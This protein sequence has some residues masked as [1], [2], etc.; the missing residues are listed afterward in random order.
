VGHYFQIQLIVQHAVEAY[1]CFTLKEKPMTRTLL[2]TG[3]SGLVSSALIE[4][5]QNSPGLKLRALLRDGSKA[6]K[7]QARGIE[8]V[9]GD[10]D[11]PDSLGAAL[12]G[13]NDLWLLTAVGPRA[14][15]NSMNALW[16]AKRAGVERV[17]RMS[18]IGAAH[19]APSR[20]GRLHALSDAELMASSL[21]WT[22]LRP[23]FFT[24][25]LLASAAT[26]QSQAAFYWDLGEGKLGMIDAR[27]IGE[28]A[29][30]VLSSPPDVHHGKVYTL[31]GPEAIS[32]EQAAA[33][34]SQGLGRTI[35]YVPVPHEVARKNMLELGMPAWLVGMLIEYG[36]AY[37]ENWG[38]FTTPHVPELLGRP[39]RSVLDFARDHVAAFRS[40]TA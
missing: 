18:A 17:V 12:A 32:M 7:L 5:L 35:R 26:I 9:P 20:N 39:A 1:A 21:K 22:I 16:A 15:E 6:A 4:S 2:L 31:T 24:Q 28:Y 8:V 27:D 37:A 36:T 25:N 29:A 14:P 40:T 11:D 13:V 30:R 3:A 38:N 10:L 34:L 23:H 19:D 33:Q